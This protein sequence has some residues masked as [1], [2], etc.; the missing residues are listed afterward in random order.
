MG[1]LVII[2]P[3]TGKPYSP[4]SQAALDAPT[5]PERQVNRSTWIDPDRPH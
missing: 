5:K 3:V 4:P 1:T 2:R